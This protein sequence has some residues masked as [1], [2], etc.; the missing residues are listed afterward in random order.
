LNFPFP[1][2]MWRQ[3]TRTPITTH[4]TLPNLRLFAFRGVSAYLEAIV[5]RITAPRLE[6]LQIWFFKQLMFSVPRLPQFVNTTENLRSDD[7]II[8]FKDNQ[9]RV[10]T[11][12]RGA[13]TVT[14]PFAVIVDCWHLD[15][16]V[17][18]VAQISNA[19]GQVFSAVEHLTL[20]YEV[21]SQSSSE[22][23]DDVDRTE[24]RNLLRSFN[25]VKTLHIK[26]GLAEELSHCLQ[27]EDKELPLE[28]LPELQG[29]TYFGRRDPNDVFTSFAI[30]MMYLH[31]S[32]IRRKG[33]HP[34]IIAHRT[35]RP[36]PSKPSSDCPAITSTSGEAGNNIDT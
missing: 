27:L 7:V 9:V 12:C 33:G 18:S 2:V 29:L 8:V 15:W 22:E 28:L 36:R 4:I 5:R 24:W 25:S 32:W 19:R 10:Q 17:S 13:N 11:F 30:S 21:H 26:D 20:E 16:Q 1:T 3:L 34:L 31:H 14:Y 35:T 6:N 23:H